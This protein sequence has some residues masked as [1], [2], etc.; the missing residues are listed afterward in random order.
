MAIGL[1]A[2]PGLNAAA[3]PGQGTL[4]YFPE[5]FFAP[6]PAS[7]PV[8]SPD[9]RR[10]AYVR[11]ERH[12]QQIEVHDLDGGGSRLLHRLS[13]AD[14]ALTS[15]GWVG[16][17][18]LHWQQN[19]ASVWAMGL[20]EAVPRRIFASGRIYIGYGFVFLGDL[21]PPQVIGVLKTEPD[22][23]QVATRS[24]RPDGDLP[25][26]RAH[27]RAEAGF[28]N[29]AAIP[30]L[31]HRRAGAD[32]RS[33]KWRDL[34]RQ[35]PP[36]SPVRFRY[37]GTSLAGRPYHFLGVGADDTDIYFATNHLGDT[38]AVYRLDLR[39]GKWSEVASDPRYDLVTL[40]GAGE[41]RIWDR[42]TQSLAGVHY[43]ADAPRASARPGRVGG[44][45]RRR[46]GSARTVPDPAHPDRQGR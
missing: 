4:G 39:Q 22:T 21:I 26:Q 36:R 16:D 12:R 9:G 46:P 23:L 6:A 28:F 45:F 19:H 3:R 37:S 5:D 1:A 2:L 40:P 13:D 7:A 33:G 11:M 42:R 24:A 10:V 25:D 17:D 32:P 44:A 14:D 30:A 43:Q 29:R 20:D 18:L 35:L 34:Q 31:L 15:L 27:R 8:L 41:G 38:T